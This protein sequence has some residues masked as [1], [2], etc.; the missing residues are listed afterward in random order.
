MAEENSYSG[1]DRSQLYNQLVE[2]GKNIERADVLITRLEKEKEKFTG[3]VSLRIGGPMDSPRSSGPSGE[4]KLPK[5][6]VINY[7]ESEA[8]EDAQVFADYAA[9]IHSAVENKLEAQEQVAAVTD[10]LESRLEGSKPTKTQSES[11]Y[12]ELDDKRD[13]NAVSC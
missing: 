8:K 1:M 6:T 5:V 12:S 4:Y 9:R 3:S 7:S 13:E 11:A 2:T 10:E